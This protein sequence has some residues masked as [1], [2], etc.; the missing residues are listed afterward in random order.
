MLY[1]KKYAPLK[2]NDILGQAIGLEQLKS[3]IQNYR[4][5]PW[6]IA[7]L[8]GPIGCGKTSAIHALAKEGGY[9]LLELNASDQRDEQSISSFLSA[10]LGQQSL[11][12]TPKIILLD[13]VDALSGREDRGGISAVLKSIERSHFPV[14]CTANDPYEDKLKPLRKASLLIPFSPVDHKMVFQALQQIAEKEGIIADTK[15]LSSL[16]RQADGDLR[17]ALIDLQCCAV[18]KQITFNDVLQLS[19][20]KRTRTILQ[21][22]QLIFKSSSAA[23]ALTA[24]DQ[25]DGEMNE[26]FLWLDENLPKEYLT[27]P[28]LAKA[29][30]HLARADVLQGRITRRQHWRFLAYIS[31]LLTAGVSSAKEEKNPG[32]ITY[33]PTLR[34]LHQW[35]ANQKNARRKS[36]AEK[37]A[38]K[39]HTSHKEAFQ[40]VPFLK[41]VLAQPEVGM[42]LGLNEEERAW[43]VS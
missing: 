18:S 27:V 34:F 2:S 16:A 39:T 33:K 6:K 40:Q 25:F 11:F 15:A 9:D 30:E 5:Q 14:I 1:T 17:A 8:H 32:F 20:R 38:A 29:Y 23:T 41:K 22:L 37:L 7:L 3:F 21:A 24:L 28:S 42:E 10:A 36:I 43:L 35:Q 13:E 26:V 31:Q 19:D 12:F 4:Q